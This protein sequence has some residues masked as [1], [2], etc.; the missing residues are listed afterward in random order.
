MIPVQLWNTVMSDMMES[1]GSVTVNT[2]GLNSSKA[3]I[4]IAKIGGMK[5]ADRRSDPETP[6]A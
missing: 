6:K 4:H 3:R 2:V 1:E 5:H